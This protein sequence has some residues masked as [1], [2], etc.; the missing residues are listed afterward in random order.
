MHPNHALVATNA[1]NADI[2]RKVEPNSSHQ[3]NALLMP[4]LWSRT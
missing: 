3:T 4:S 2:H 1:V